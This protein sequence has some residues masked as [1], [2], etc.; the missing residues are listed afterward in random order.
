MIIG[1]SG[2]MGSGKDTFGQMLQD[3]LPSYTLKSFAFKLKQVASIISGIPIENFEDPEFKMG[4][5]TSEWDTS[6]LKDSPSKYLKTET[7][8]MTVREFLQKLGTDG[9]KHNLHSSVWINALF[10]DYK[11]EKSEDFFPNWI[12]TDVRFP[13][14]ADAVK[15]KGGILIRIER[16]NIKQGSSKTHVSETAMDHY[17]DYDIIVHNEGDLESLKKRAK[18]V[19][20]VIEK[21]EIKYF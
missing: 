12:I 21:E 19:A 11:K 3:E 10:S 2:K 9:L 14:E 15:K 6:I 8:Q 16:S 1:I 18:E 20:E 4:Y 5:M 17:S 13:D 7:T